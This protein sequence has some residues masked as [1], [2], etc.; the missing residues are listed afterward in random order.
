MRR[1]RPPRTIQFQPTRSENETVCRQQ[2]GNIPKT[3]G[4][5]SKVSLHV[6]TRHRDRVETRGNDVR[7]IQ[8]GWQGRK[9]KAA[10]RLVAVAKRADP[11]DVASQRQVPRPRVPRGEGE[12]SVQL[13]RNIALPFCEGSQRRLFLVHA[14]GLVEPNVGGKEN[15]VFAPGKLSR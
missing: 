15:S 10:P 14:V 3:G 11:D 13:V 4:A 7:P 5:A 1:V 8:S 6:R 12:I 9:G 2:P